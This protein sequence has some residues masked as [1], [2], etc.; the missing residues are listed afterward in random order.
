MNFF[1]TFFL[2]LFFLQNSV[3]LAN[4]AKF[5]EYRYTQYLGLQQQ[6]QNQRVN[7]L[8]KQRIYNQNPT[9]NIRYPSAN[10][11]YPNIQKY[12]AVPTQRRYSPQYYNAYYR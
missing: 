4:E 6:L 10:N 5:G 9:R 7:A 1:A 2:I 3:I 12:S 11:P 8:R